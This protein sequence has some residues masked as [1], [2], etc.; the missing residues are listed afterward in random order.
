MLREHIKPALLRGKLCN[1]GMW[2]VESKSDNLNCKTV[3]EEF[4]FLFCFV[5]RQWVKWVPSNLH[6][7]VKFH[8]ES[9]EGSKF[10]FI[11][12]MSE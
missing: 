1:V 12:Q 4:F 10:L 2:I 6:K 7:N 11:I 5:F 9:E 3:C 8:F